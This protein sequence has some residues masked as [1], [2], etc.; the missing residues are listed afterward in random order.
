MSQDL[1]DFVYVE[2]KE[3]AFEIEIESRKLYEA[4][5]KIYIDKE[6][7]NLEA[8]YSKKEEE[9]LTKYKIERS[10]TIND[11]RNEVLKATNKALLKLLNSCQL[12]LQNKIKD[13]NYY[14]E[15]LKQ[16]I[17]QGLV[18]LREGVVKIRCLPDDVE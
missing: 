18:K 6:R 4:K 11:S 12:T 17:T 1:S 10:I 16:L 9:K 7:K 3:R 14:K 8:K 2:A 13:R 15:L 5:R